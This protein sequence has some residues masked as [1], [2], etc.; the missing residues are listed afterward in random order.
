M[1]RRVVVTEPVHPDALA[2]LRDA[3]WQVIGPPT[4]LAPANLHPADALLVRIRALTAADVAQFA[5]ISKH[6]VGVDNIPMDAARAAGITVTN[7]PG[8]NATAVAE[9]ALL[10]MLALA[11]NLDG[12]RAAR[13]AAPRVPGLDGK[14]LL[15]VG[16]GASGQ[17]LANHAKGLGVKVTINSRVLSPARAAGFAV[18]PDLAAALPYADIVSLHCPL[19]DTT[20]GMLNAQTLALLPPGALVINCA[21]G[22]LIDESALIAQLQNGHLGGAGLDVTAHEPLPE[23]DPLRCAPNIILTPHAAALSDGSFRAM[24]MMAAQNILDHFNGCLR[25]EHRLLPR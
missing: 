24:G 16:Y 7:T 20:R 10:L 13:G 18:E 4:T 1:A 19:T 6:G 15:I 11:R 2:L 14:R 22:G 3:G 5:M 17:R 23:T 12:Q 21:R 8:A 25:A 9:Q